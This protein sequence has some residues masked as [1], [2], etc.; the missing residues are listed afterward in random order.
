MASE[1]LK[2]FRYEKTKLVHIYINVYKKSYFAMRPEYCLTLRHHRM[3]L[4][5]FLLTQAIVIVI[6]SNNASLIQSSMIA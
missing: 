5:I 6:K 4:P 2:Q 3:A 1:A